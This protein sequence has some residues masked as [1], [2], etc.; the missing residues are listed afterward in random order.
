[1]SVITTNCNSTSQKLIHNTVAHGR[2]GGATPPWRFQSPNIK[3]QGY[4]HT[5]EGLAWLSCQN[6]AKLLTDICNSL[7]NLSC[8]LQ[9]KSLKYDFYLLV[10]PECVR[11]NLRSKGP[12]TQNV[13]WGG[14]HMPQT[15]LGDTKI[16]QHSCPLPTLHPFVTFSERN[17]ARIYYVIINITVWTGHVQGAQYCA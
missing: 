1:M 17:T 13:S 16:T 6:G 12:M 8:K 7:S 2:G 4:R 5:I 11:I 14:G 3:H 15:P 10:A 9:N